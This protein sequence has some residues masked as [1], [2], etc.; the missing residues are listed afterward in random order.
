MG[1]FKKKLDRSTNSKVEPIVGAKSH[2]VDQEL[3]NYYF[4]L[5]QIFLPP[6]QQEQK[7]ITSKNVGPYKKEEDEVDVIS[8]H[9]DSFS[10][11]TNMTY[12]K[13][14]H[15]CSQMR[16]TWQFSGSIVINNVQLQLGN[17]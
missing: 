8:T 10:H 1:K 14:E 17:Q 2:H 13:G 4:S 5:A 9:L 6:L 15:Y 11:I 12:T 7:A 3:I 16:M